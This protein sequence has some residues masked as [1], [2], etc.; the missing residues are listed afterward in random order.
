MAAETLPPN[1]VTEV[2]SYNPLR[3]FG[4]V[5][6]GSGSEFLYW[7]FINQNVDDTNGMPLPPLGTITMGSERADRELSKIPLY[8]FN[9]STSSVEIRKEEII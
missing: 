4:A 1:T 8:I 5:F 3:K 6:N 7:S 2:L 9:P